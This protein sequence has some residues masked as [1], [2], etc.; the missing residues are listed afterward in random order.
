MIWSST[1]ASLCELVVKVL[2]FIPRIYSRER[3]TGLSQDHIATW[4]LDAGLSDSFCSH[5]FA[6]LS[7]EHL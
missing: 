6:L 5:D 4:H 7:S 3:L 2:S 1:P